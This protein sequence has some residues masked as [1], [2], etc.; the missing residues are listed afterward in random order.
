MGAQRMF[1]AG[2]PTLRQ[3]LK[4]RHAPGISALLFQNVTG[5]LVIAWVIKTT[6]DITINTDSVG[7]KP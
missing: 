7:R 1:R 4:V 5:G 6:K 3:V 2:L